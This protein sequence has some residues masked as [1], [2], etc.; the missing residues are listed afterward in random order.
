MATLKT[1]LVDG[2][3]NELK[4]A[5]E[6]MKRR[7]TDNPADPT[8]ISKNTRS[9]RIYHMDRERRVLHLIRSLIEANPDVKLSTD[10]QETFALITT[11][12][13]ERQTTRYQFEVGDSLLDI[14]TEYENLS[15]K[16]LDAKL[17]KLGLKM[18]YA[19]T[20]KVVK[21]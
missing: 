16:D 6:V 18:D 1:S 20:K 8:Y 13:T 4:A 11:L 10:D 2:K 5:V 17:Q 15:R 19:K 21:A 3:I 12:A 7:N 14:M 9:N